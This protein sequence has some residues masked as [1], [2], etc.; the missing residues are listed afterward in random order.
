MKKYLPITLVELLVFFA[1]V[2][3]LVGLLAP[4]ISLVLNPP[5]QFQYG[6]RVYI[7]DGF[8]K[9]KSG[10]VVDKNSSFEY[11]VDIDDRKVKINSKEMTK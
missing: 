3:V 2:G 7:K 5:Q 11:T 1:I 4:A 8:F 9:G 6:D 10:V